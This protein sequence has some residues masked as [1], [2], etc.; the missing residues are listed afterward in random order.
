MLER[1]FGTH[2]ARGWL[3]QFDAALKN[4]PVSADIFTEDFIHQQPKIVHFVIVYGDKNYAIFPQEIAG[5][6]KPGIHHRQPA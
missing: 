5:E 3:L 2:N 1:T 6:E 4:V